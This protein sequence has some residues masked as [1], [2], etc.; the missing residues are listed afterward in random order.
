M[1]QLIDF[2]LVDE[3]I[4]KWIA[5]TPESICNF[6]CRLR[7]LSLFATK[8]VCWCKI[9]QRTSF[10]HADFQMIGQRKLSSHHRRHFSTAPESHFHILIYLICLNC[11]FNVERI[12]PCLSSNK[13]FIY[14]LEL[15]TLKQS[16]AVGLK[17]C[18]SFWSR[19]ALDREATVA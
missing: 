5:M 15:N 16:Y 2:E 11:L 9:E 13:L 18:C 8:R 7:G 12:H 1:L 19:D 4:Y 14:T 3:C 6:Y 17:G 10:Y